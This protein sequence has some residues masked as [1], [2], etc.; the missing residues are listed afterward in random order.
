LWDNHFIKFNYKRRLKLNDVSREICVSPN[1]LNN[2]F[3]EITGK[4]VMQYL[5]DYKI[6]IACY[7]LGNTAKTLK[8][9]AEELGY[10]DQ[11]H[12]SKD[13]KNHIGYSPLQYRR[14]YLNI[15]LEEPVI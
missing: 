8:A 4:T 13:F 1:H 9:I 11:Y 5:K 12:F 14:K 7:L 10:Y 3:K 2:I 6:K 15:K